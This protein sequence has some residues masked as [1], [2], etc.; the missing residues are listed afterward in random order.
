LM[1]TLPKDVDVAVFLADLHGEPVQDLEPLSGGYWSSAYGYRL[2]DNEQVLRLGDMREGFEMDR[3]AMAFRREGLPIP[4]VLDIGDGPSGLTY[5]I[6]VRHHGRF[7]E[8][9]APDEA[10]R[11]GPTLAALLASLLAV[12]AAPDQ[13]VE[14]FGGAGAT[15]PARG[16]RSWLLSGLVDDP[17][18]RVSGWRA[19][20]AA[21][22][23]IDRLFVA[24]ERRIDGLLDA[25][26]ERRDLV[27][28]DLY[29]GNV[30]IDEDAAKVTGVFSWK[31]S[32][33]G[34]FLLDVALS[35]FWTPWHPGIGAADVWG[36][37]TTAPAFTA[38]EALLVDAPLRHHCYELQI[39]ASHMGWNAW[40]GDHETQAKLVAHLSEVLERGPLEMPDSSR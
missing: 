37:V 23:D 12:P 4:D 3:A 36:R 19:M 15:E 13:P 32:V 6:S 5:A 35:T 38:D 34:D 1:A 40:N 9:A 21:E 30:L 17:A 2:G 10:E 31:C 16:W 28:G 11:V 8:S 29:Y 33:R 26:P 24:C 39:G 25:C 14:W 18:R 20:L 7:I 22:P 27:H